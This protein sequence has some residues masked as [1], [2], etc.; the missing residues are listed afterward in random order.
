MTTRS[1]R[2]PAPYL[3]TTI[4]LTGTVS[5][6]S[7]PLD[8]DSLAA[9]TYARILLTKAG[10]L[11]APVGGVIRRALAVYVRHLDKADT[12]HQDEASSLRRACNQRMPD[13][14]TQQATTARLLELEAAP[15][16]APL[17]RFGEVLNGT[18]HAAQVESFNA[19]T[20]QLLAKVVTHRTRC[21]RGAVTSTKCPALTRASARVGQ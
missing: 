16:G 11:R 13:K 18:G 8:A 4:P 21:T 1:E 7:A 17:L 20:E 3:R 9:V 15:C 5:K 10:H 19:R 6:A 14:A 2:K 12:N